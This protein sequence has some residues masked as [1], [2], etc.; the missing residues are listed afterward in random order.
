M[1][2]DADQSLAA[3]QQPEQN[4]LQPGSSDFT[5]AVSAVTNP[6]GGTAKSTE[7]TK[8][9]AQAG[10]QGAR[11]P[12]VAVIGPG[13]Y[14]P[15]DAGMMI[16]IGLL[17]QNPLRLAGPRSAAAS[18][19]TP[20]SGQIRAF[21]NNLNFS[22]AGLDAGRNVEP[23]GVLNSLTLRPHQNTDIV[24]QTLGLGP[25]LNQQLGGLP[26]KALVVNVTDPMNV[27]QFVDILR[28]DLRGQNAGVVM[29]PIPNVNGTPAYFDAASPNAQTSRGA[30]P[31]SSDIAPHT[32]VEQARG[33]A[34]SFTQ[35]GAAPVVASVPLD[36]ATAAALS[37][38]VGQAT[39]KPI[40]IP[41]GTVI[42]APLNSAD[43]TV[44]LDALK[45][46]VDLDPAKAAKVLEARVEVRQ[47][48]A[49]DLSRM[50]LSSNGSSPL[51]NASAVMERPQD[52]LAAIGSRGPTPGARPGNDGPAVIIPKEA[53][54]DA[55]GKTAVYS[56]SGNIGA[57]QFGILNSNNVDVTAVARNPSRLGLPEDKVAGAIPSDAQTVFVTAS[58]PTNPD[59]AQMLASNLEQVVSLLARQLPSGAAVFVTTNPPNDLAAAIQALRPDVSSFGDLYSDVA[60][61]GMFTAAKGAGNAPVVYGPHNDN[62]I[63]VGQ[64]GRIVSAV[65]RYGL[66]IREMSNVPASN[67][68][69]GATE[70]QVSVA[71][72]GAAVVNGA[73][74]VLHGETYP[75]APVLG[76]A[77]ARA[78]SD[79]AGVPVNP[80]ISFGALY[81]MDRET[82]AVTLD[83][84]AL[85]RFLDG[86]PNANAP[87]PEPRLVEFV[88]RTDIRN[89]SP[90]KMAKAIKDAL[91]IDVTAQQAGA[92]LNTPAV[93]LKML[94]NV[95]AVQNGAWE[96][97]SEALVSIIA[98]KNPD[99]T[100]E[101]ARELIANGG[102]LADGRRAIDLMS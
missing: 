60:R 39:G 31:S 56:A 11:A 15:K 70:K 49:A 77:N 27:T 93:R 26:P 23:T 68:V 18:E 35:S 92:L 76:P 99:V 90:A 53:Y 80:Q 37:D 67:G 66:N 69:S 81:T 9:D 14:G 102:A 73:L 20:Y 62:M 94:Q 50:I 57:A 32:V 72:T 12:V 28:P 65:P 71:P 40:S 34:D 64:D 1:R 97:T 5:K 41:A 83:T 87:A 8:A 38:Y 16:T 98:R 52:V 47:R 96:Q 45:K 86:V 74:H 75:A 30:P 13:S 36:A 100:A 95:I 85:Q 24:F 33:L 19:I 51:N 88:A 55:L 79:L 10:E 7:S 22:T 84:A 25:A 17:G 89:Q 29:Q 3:A 61:S 82:K 58:I 44:D 91:D 4:P 101:T 78:L 54:Q 63:A 42:A 43:R 46:A 48:L 21:T 2:V 6:G 59:R